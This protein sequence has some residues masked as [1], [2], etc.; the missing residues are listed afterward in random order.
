MAGINFTA[1]AATGGTFSISGSLTLN[2]NAVAAETVTATPAGATVTQT[3]SPH[4]A[5]P[6]NNILGVDSPI[7]IT[8]A[9]TVAYIKIQTNITHPRRGDLTLTLTA[10]DGTLIFVYGLFAPTADGTANLV[11][12]F[13]DQ[14][15]PDELFSQ[16]NGLAANGTW[17]LNVADQGVGNVG[18]FN[19]WSLTIGYAGGKTVQAVSTSAGTYTIGGLSAGT[20]IVTPVDDFTVFTPGSRTVTVGPSATAVNFTGSIISGLKGR[21]AANGA[22]ELARQIQAA[23]RH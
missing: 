2:G 10:P 9:G 16:F 13:P 19:S 4:A 12:V 7:T 17:T 15:K 14:T 21:A 18:T 1:T 6:D 3:A 11:T 22:R 5:I 8:Q 23:R 20:Y